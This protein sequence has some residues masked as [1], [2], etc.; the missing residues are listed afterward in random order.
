M[1]DGRRVANLHRYRVAGL[2]RGE[3][4]FF[5]CIRRIGIDGLGQCSKLKGRGLLKYAH[6][7]LEKTANVLYILGF[8]SISFLVNDLLSFLHRVRAIGIGHGGEA[9][10]IAHK[11]L[12]ADDAHIRGIPTNGN[13]SHGA[14][15]TRRFNIKNRQAIVVCIGNV[16]ALFIR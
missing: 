9:F 2:S 8:G 6:R 12:L 10:S 3:G 1:F 11:N 14:A 15:F 5:F 7:A 13:K 16:Q 4:F